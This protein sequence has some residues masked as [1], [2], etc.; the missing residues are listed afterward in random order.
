LN[1]TPAKLTFAIIL[2]L[3]LLSGAFLRYSDLSQP[4]LDF[5]PTRQLFSAVK[6]RGI[7]YQTRPDLP[8]WQRE[9]SYRQWQREATIEPPLVENIAVFLYTLNGTEN[10][11]YPRAVSA[12]FWMLA[13][14]FLGLLALNL[15]GSP[16]AAIFSL[17]FFLLLPYGILASRAFQPDPLMLLLII[18]FWWSIQQWA[19]KNT[20][21]WAILSGLAGGFAVFVK[22]PAV[23]FVA[24]GAFGAIL[25]Y[26]SL[27]AAIKNIK[28]WLIALLSLFPAA[29]YLYYGLY[30]A[31]F[32]G[33]QF[34]GRFF[35]T[36]WLDPYF[37][38]RWLLKVDFAI[39]V[40]W[41]SLA[42]LGWLIFS[43]RPTRLFLSTLWVGYIL[44]GLVFPHHIASHDYYSLPL[45]LI[46]ALS[47]A[48]LIVAILSHINTKTANRSAQIIFFFIVCAFLITYS[49]TT[50]LNLRQ[51]DTRQAAQTY[52]EIGQ[53][54][55]H[56]PGITALTE[57]YA[58]PLAYYG[59]QNVRLWQ[60]S[61]DFE[62]AF[63][64]QTRLQ[65]YF[66][67]TD[68]AALARQPELAEKLETY[69]IFAQTREY[70]IYDLKAIRST[71]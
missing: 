39:G 60:E 37:Y 16:P 48:P 3:I 57:E 40:F 9:L 63:A 58:Y 45:L 67:I 25:A 6:A 19:R 59:W 23:F 61:P 64:E 10:T 15:T 68:F 71:P 69:A 7:Y 5:H 14:I 1:S 62:Q 32:L 30:I 24:A 53:V 8:E 36:F 41:L 4:L 43:S 44:Y 38:L 35:P 42:A 18:I 54:L 51:N 12:T 17:G 56:Q 11:A 31:G 47:L 34:G 22:L 13:A 46:T 2:A 26:S 65:A 33:Q 50:Y 66:L 28:T 55:A 29:I 20:W 21:P 52:A 70:I 49:I 27:T